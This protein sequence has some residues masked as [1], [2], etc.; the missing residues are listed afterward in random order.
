[1]KGVSSYYAK[2]PHTD[3]ESRSVSKEIGP[4]GQRAL[5]GESFRATQASKNQGY[6]EVPNESS[7]VEPVDSEELDRFIQ[8][9]IHVWQNSPTSRVQEWFVR[10][11][12]EQR[13]SADE[14][15]L[16]NTLSR[17][18]RMPIR[19]CTQYMLQCTSMTSRS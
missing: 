14:L 8:N 11:H 18:R 4:S 7:L 19:R 9:K 13:L 2:S 12:K 1:M 16:D 3:S 6:Y 5:L 17:D 15:E 10:E